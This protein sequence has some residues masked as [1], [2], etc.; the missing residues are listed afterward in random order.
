MVF[1]LLFLSS[2]FFPRHYM[3]GWYRTVADWN[4]MSHIV[5][6]MQG[7]MN[8]DLAADQFVKAW[9]IPLA[10]AVIGIAF[11]LRSLNKRLAAS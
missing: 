6:G 7:F 1:V 8:H 4:P 11:A 2:A 9:L 10:V 5:E 3:T